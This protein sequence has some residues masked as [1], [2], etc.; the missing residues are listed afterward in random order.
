MTTSPHNQAPNPDAC[1]SCPVAA[2]TAD[3]T[4][5]T[6]LKPGQT[7]TVCQCALDPADASVLRAM[8]LRPNATLR[9]C[10]A[11]EPCVVEVL[12]GEGDHAS[13]CRI[14]LSKPLAARVMVAP[15]QPPTA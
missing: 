3:A 5:L 6:A 10:R 7:A 4:R 8:G 12:Y 11:G 1:P 9:V 14:G 13:S 2:H 15:L